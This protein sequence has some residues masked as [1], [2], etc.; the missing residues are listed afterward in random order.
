MTFHFLRIQARVVKIL[1]QISS[2]KTRRWRI[3]VRKKWEKNYGHK[4]DAMS[5]GEFVISEINEN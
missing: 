3:R 4:S 1:G 5:I 2:V